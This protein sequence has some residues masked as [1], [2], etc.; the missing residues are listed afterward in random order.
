MHVSENRLNIKET[1]DFDIAYTSIDRILC[2]IIPMESNIY[3]SVAF[4]SFVANSPVGY[5]RNYKLIDE[6][7]PFACSIFLINNCVAKMSFSFENNPRLIEL[8]AQCVEDSYMEEEEDD[9]I[10]LRTAKLIEEKLR[11]KK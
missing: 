7:E 8:Y 11:A 1:L 4:R 2:S 6:N 3:N 5:T 9:N 10:I